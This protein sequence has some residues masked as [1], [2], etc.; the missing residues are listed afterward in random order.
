MSRSATNLLD[1]SGL[2]APER[3]EIRDFFQF[4]LTRRTTVKKTDISYKF[5]DLCG[6][7]NWKGD[8]VAAQRSLRD[9]W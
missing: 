7:V 5:T 3:R 8:A 2:P 6:T 9:E 1:L 4:L